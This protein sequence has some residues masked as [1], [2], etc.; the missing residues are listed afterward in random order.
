MHVQRAEHDA[1]LCEQGIAI[2][3]P[4][5]GARQD[6]FELTG[7]RRGRAAHIEHVR[8]GAQTRELR[9]AIEPKADDEYLERDTLIN[10][11]RCGTVKVG[12]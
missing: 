9:A 10:M 4:F 7:P 1:D 3:Q 11:Y 5:A 8:H 6:C 12:T 2:D